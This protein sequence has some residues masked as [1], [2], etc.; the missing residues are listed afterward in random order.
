MAECLTPGQLN[1][2]GPCTLFAK[3]NTNG[4]NLYTCAD[5]LYTPAVCPDDPTEGTIN[6]GVA[7]AKIG[8]VDGTVPDVLVQRDASSIAYAKGFQVD[9]ASCAQADQGTRVGPSDVSI[10]LIAPGLALPQLRLRGYGDTPSFGGVQ[11]D[12]NVGYLSISRFF[13]KNG[14]AL[15]V[16]TGSPVASV[17]GHEFYLSSLDPAGTQTLMKL[18]A[19][20]GT[21]YFPAWTY[22]SDI[23][24]KA[25]VVPLDGQ[26]SLEVVMGI[27]PIAY[28]M[29]GKRYNGFSAQ[30][31]GKMLPDAVS[32]PATKNDPMT[33]RDGDIL[34]NLVAA[35][36]YLTARVEALEAKVGA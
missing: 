34:A 32:E 22:V 24:L 7:F 17:G 30:D 8:S 2:D 31:V 10:G 35:V 20:A 12:N 1:I 14:A 33:M 29:H 3:V 16:N 26:T 11:A 5:F 6:A 25:N 9:I 36:K 28:T 18:E 27:S 15:Y 19:A 4:A 23:R 13:T 21:L